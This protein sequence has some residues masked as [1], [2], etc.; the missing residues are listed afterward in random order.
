MHVDDRVRQVRWHFVLDNTT[1]NLTIAPPA[2]Y[3]ETAKERI[4]LP[5]LEQSTSASRA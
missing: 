2:I 5:R 1:L 3:D 4:S